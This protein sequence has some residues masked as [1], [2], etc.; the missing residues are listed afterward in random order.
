MVP[1]FPLRQ[2]EVVQAVGIGGVVLAQR[3]EADLSRP[4]EKGQ[5][6]GVVPKPQVYLP[7]VVQAVS[8]G[9]VVLAS[10]AR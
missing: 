7:E 1:Q 9:G 10:T 3:G 5:S 2:P 4:A 6:G 8:V